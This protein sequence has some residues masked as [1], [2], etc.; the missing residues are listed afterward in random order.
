MPILDVEVVNDSAEL[1][2]EDLAKQLTDIA[3]DILECEEGGTWVKV[4]SL[5]R[6]QYAE[7]G[8]VPDQVRPVF[9]SVLL[10]QCPSEGDVMKDQIQRLSASFAKVCDRPEE[11]IHI[12]YL[13]SA[14]G[15]IAFGGELV[16]A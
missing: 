16:S 13:P 3:G 1:L 11:N 9:V 4:R 2:K 8:G 6:E 7:N 12:L 5:P 10:G 15:R 14:V